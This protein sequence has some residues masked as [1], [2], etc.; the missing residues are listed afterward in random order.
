MT[1]AAH[2]LPCPTCAKVT[3]HVELTQ[4]TFAKFPG[5]NGGQQEIEVKALV[6]CLTCHQKRSP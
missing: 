2:K 6:M 3:D 1:S 5:R 4:R